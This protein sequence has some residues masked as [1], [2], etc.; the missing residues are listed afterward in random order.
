[1]QPH[2]TDSVNRKRR[3]TGKRLDG[4]QPEGRKKFEHHDDVRKKIPVI[5][6]LFPC[7]G[8]QQPSEEREK[9]EHA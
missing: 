6:M 5:R 3:F 4:K 8:R 2:A 9:Y 7:H 1:M